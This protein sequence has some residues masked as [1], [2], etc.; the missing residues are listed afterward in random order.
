MKRIYS[1]A[2]IFVMVV[3]ISGAGVAGG[4]VLDRQVL[5]GYVPVSTIDKT[6]SPDFQLMAQAWNLIQQ[7]AEVISKE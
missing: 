1:I 4:V 3:L 6:N 7:A 5:L 2:L